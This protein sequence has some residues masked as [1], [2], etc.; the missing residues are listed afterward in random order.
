MFESS[1]LSTVPKIDD[2]SDTLAGDS[3]TVV[4]TFETLSTSNDCLLPPKDRRADRFGNANCDLSGGRHDVG[5]QHPV[6]QL[7]RGMNQQE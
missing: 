6:P 5:P 4:S 3:P 2:E 7:Q 1:N